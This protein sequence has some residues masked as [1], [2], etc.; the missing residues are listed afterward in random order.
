MRSLRYTWLAVP[1][2]LALTARAW[3]QAEDVNPLSL[4][5][6]AA[7][8]TPAKAAPPPDYIEG[9]F[10]GSDR[11][12]LVR[13]HIQ[14]GGKPYYAAWEDYMGKLFDYFDVK[15]KGYLTKE[16][17][18]RMP[19][20]N[21]MQQL[22]QGGIGV[23]RGRQ[24]IQFAEV[25]TNKDG[26]VSR[27]EFLAFFRRYGFNPL[28][29]GV[30]RNEARTNRVTDTLYQYLDT[31][32]SGKLTA[33][34]LAKADVI[35]ARL[36]ENEDELISRDELMPDRVN[37]PYFGEPVDDY[38]NVRRQQPPQPSFLQMQPGQPVEGLAKQLMT[39]YNKAKNGKLSRAEIGLPRADFDA[40][41]TNKDG[42][43][44]EKELAAF[45]KRPPDLELMARLGKSLSVAE[46]D[47]TR[48]RRRSIG[49]YSDGG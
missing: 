14:I 42:Y 24:P 19:H 28:N 10:L 16:E 47:W 1:L 13:V 21:M 3:G 8:A 18:D 43:L 40:L 6:K 41:D 34:K 39:R 46:I 37:N 31:D 32:K 22:L 33:E 29:F 45:F 30:G 20:P 15:G 38:G 17:V 7:T 25:D 12:V 23:G 48:P 27:D 4:E 11:P 9:V 26:K 5:D 44:D 35:L 49:L 2:L 36:D